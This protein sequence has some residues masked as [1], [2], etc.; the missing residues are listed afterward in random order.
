MGELL[1]SSP[2]VVTVANTGDVDEEAWMVMLDA[3]GHVA[4]DVGA[5]H[6]DLPLTSAV[7]WT[8]YFATDGAG[9]WKWE[10]RLL[11]HLAHQ[12]AGSVD[13]DS[14]LAMEAEVQSVWP[15]QIPPMSLGLA[16]ELTEAQHGNVARMIR[17]GGGANFSVPGSGKTAMACATWAALRQLG[18]VDRMLVV[19]PL[20]AHE[21]WAT[22]PS[23]V[24]GVP[25]PTVAIRPLRPGPEDICVVNYERLESQ[26]QL[27]R[28]ISWCRVN[29]ALVVFDEAHRA[30]RGAAGVRGAA[31]LTLSRTARR[32]MVLTGTP[33]PNAASDLA[34]VLEL[35]YPGRGARLA[36]GSPSACY[37]GRSAG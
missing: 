4:Q 37:A 19:A 22:E 21:A 25:V 1:L 33:R 2:S 28:F 18:D 17:L 31:A 6:V 34:A 8:W 26:A 15:A 29:R 30:K 13:V 11:E 3:L 36:A 23:E 5:S 7:Q 32:P 27:E 14:V 20:S 12:L 16:R 9:T 24:F 10:D 35:A